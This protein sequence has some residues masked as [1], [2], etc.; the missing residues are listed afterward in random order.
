MRHLLNYLKSS[1]KAILT[2]VVL[3]L[4]GLSIAMTS[5][6]STKLHSFKVIPN[7]K[8]IQIT[9][10]TVWEK[11][12]ESFD[13]ER[14][15]D[16]ENFIKVDEV[17]GEGTSEMLTSYHYNDK[18]VEADKPYFYRLKYENELGEIA[19]SEVL[20]ATT[21]PKPTTTKTDKVGD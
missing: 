10:V 11:D 16:K 14:S 2:T 7:K 13:I 4:A 21:T 5:V 19:Y 20:K 15:I 6:T 1:P 17:K 8:H 3:I 9:W 12:N 18:K